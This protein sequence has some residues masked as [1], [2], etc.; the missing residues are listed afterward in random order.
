[1]VFLPEG[2]RSGAILSHSI[3]GRFSPLNLK[4]ELTILKCNKTTATIRQLKISFSLQS[5]EKKLS[6]KFLTSTGLTSLLSTLLA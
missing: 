4:T 6:L 3:F 5:F 1:M 2:G